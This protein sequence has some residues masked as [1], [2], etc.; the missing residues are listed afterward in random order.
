[1][2]QVFAAVEKIHASPTMC[3]LS[4]TGSGGPA[5]GWLM[6]VG[7]CSKT[8]LEGT[9]PYAHS[10]LYSF[11]PD[12]PGKSVSAAASRS[13]ALASYQ[14]ALQLRDNESQPVVGIGATGSIATTRDRRGFDEVYVTCWG[15]AT[16]KSYHCR[17]DKELK[18]TRLQEDQIVCSLII[19]ALAD[20][21]G[22]EFEVPFKLESNEPIKVSE[23]ETPKVWFSVD[24]ER[25]D[26]QGAVPDL[27][28]GVVPVVVPGSFNPLHNG[29]KAMGQAAT[30]F[31][32]QSGQEARVFFELSITNVDKAPISEEDLL[33]RAAQFKGQYD[34]VATRTPKFA[35]KV[36]QFPYHKFVVGFD[37]ARRLLDP[38]Y[39]NGCV[40]AM[41][42]ELKAIKGV[43][44]SFLVAGRTEGDE[45]K[46]VK[47]LVMPEGMDPADFADL[48]VELTTF[49]R[50]DISSTELRKAQQEAQ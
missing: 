12:K 22:V 14:K 1:M 27:A 43:G 10:A 15:A 4:I 42:E 49:Q 26:L 29:H 44:C 7:G 13:M 47:D 36:K 45:F 35:D 25:H 40:Q 48:F 39:T 32:K 9:I 41:L 8:L 3:C 50:L 16:A 38:K 2:A 5:L 37:T 6:S 33:T 19:L 23:F 18:R 17:M 46:T 31:I 28:P 20:A 24:G 30:E 34:L 11:L 21:C